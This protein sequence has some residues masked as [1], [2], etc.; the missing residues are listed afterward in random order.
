MELEIKTAEEL[1]DHEFEAR[2]A[3]RRQGPQAEVLRWIVR[4]FIECGGPIAVT[5]VEAAF[6][7][8]PAGVRGEVTALDTQDLIV[9][10]EGKIT[11]AYPFSAAPTPFTVA[12]PDEG[13]RF[14]CCAVDALGIA[15]MLG[16]RIAIRAPCHHCGEPLELAADPTGPLGAGDVMVWV[17]K[18]G[19]DGRRACT[20]L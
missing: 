5:E 19:E 17:G 14:A 20:S 1:V 11:L 8:S 12:L 4:A 15:P 13:E 3:A 10:A 2:W 6:R 7:E 18:R 9:I 16:E